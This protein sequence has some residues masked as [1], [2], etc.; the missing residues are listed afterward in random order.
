MDKM[1]RY[2]VLIAG[3]PN[4]VSRFLRKN[5]S[6][7]DNFVKGNRTRK[8]P[9]GLPAPIAAIHYALRWLANALNAVPIGIE[10]RKSRLCFLKSLAPCV[11]HAVLTFKAPMPFV[12]VPS[13]IATCTPH[14]A[15]SK[16]YQ[17]RLQAIRRSA[18]I[19]GVPIADCR[20]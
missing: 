2:S 10:S 11:G 18:I 6:N 20:G 7:E 19:R 13:I 16:N 12:V 3:E 14:N 4:K 5:W 1:R 17:L 9:L 8:W 15:E